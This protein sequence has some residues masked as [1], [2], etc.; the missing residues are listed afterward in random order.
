[1]NEFHR[2][3]F[4]K[5]FKKMTPIQV[6]KIA[7]ERPGRAQETQQEQNDAE[8]EENLFKPGDEE[9]ATEEMKP[10]EQEEFMDDT[11]PRQA[12]AS[13]T[14]IQL[15]NFAEKVAPDWKKLAVKLGTA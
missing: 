15:Q 3:E 11:N 12:A 4:D 10:G 5:K 14:L 1:M 13:V 6:R 7:A 2:S 8:M 9:Q